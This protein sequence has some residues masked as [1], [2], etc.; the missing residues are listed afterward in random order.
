MTKEQYMDMILTR[1]SHK[2]KSGGLFYT[3]VINQRLNTVNSHA[4]KSYDPGTVLFIGAQI[5]KSQD[6]E[7]IVEYNFLIGRVQV[8]GSITLADLTVVP[9]LTILTFDYVWTQPEVKTD[10]NGD[11]VWFIKSIHIA[12]L[13]GASSFSAFGLQGPI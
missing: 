9:P 2:F 5:H 6:D 13:Y 1:H 7:F 10:L 3:D 4:W 8:T 11:R 12:K